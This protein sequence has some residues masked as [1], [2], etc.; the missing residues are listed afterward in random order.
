MSDRPP[1]NRILVANRGEIAVRIMQTC[2]DMGIGT[3][4]V[5]SE[6]DANAL[7]VQRA[8]YAFC[9]GPPAALQSYL[10]ADKIIEAALEAG[11]EAIHPG[12]GFLAENAGFAR[13]VLEAGLVW[14]GPPP[15]V[16]AL[17]G[18]KIASKFL[19][20]QAKV[21]V[22]PGYYG[23]DQ[24]PERIQAEAERIGYPLMVKAAAGGGGKGMRAVERADDLLSALEGARREA[25]SA[26]GDER[27]FLERLLTHPRHI[28]IQIFADSHENAM[29]LGER[30][31]S[32][33]RRHQKVLEESPSPILTSDLRT[34]M[35][36]SALRVV[37]AAGYVNAGTVE[38]L[39]SGDEYYFLEVNTRLQVEH[40]VTEAVTGLD[41]VRLQIEVAAGRPLR[42]SQLDIRL[43]GHAIEARVY[44]EDPRNGFLPATGTIAVFQPPLGPGVRNDVGIFEGAH[45]SPYYDPILAKLVVR[46]E[47]R[48][49]AVARLRRALEHY[50][51]LGV[52]T[53]V[54]FLRWVA[55]HEAFESG[56]MDT[57]FVA[58]YW[59]PGDRDLPAEILVA[60][61]AFDVGASPPQE[62]GRSNPWHQTGGWRMGGSRRVFRYRFGDTV[63]TVS[64]ARAD[65]GRW[66]ITADGFDHEVRIDQGRPGVIVLRQGSAVETFGCARVEGG[67]EVAWRGETY[68]LARPVT[69]EAAHTQT[70]SLRADLRAPMPGTVIKVAVEPGQQVGAHQPLVVMEAMKM[71]HV[72][73]AP[74]PGVVQE[75]MYSEGDLVPA[76]AA[77]VR[78][79]ES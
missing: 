19:A 3:V 26:F 31:C 42:M 36:D 11:A 4:A 58:R 13:A 77:V 23:D 30:E 55:A 10:R 50:L 66:C 57:D 43:R 56:R 71:E 24:S 22:I 78:L 18:D 72:I 74:H 40:P 69:V 75:V 17:L 59:H 33:Q 52:T 68:R 8:D 76:G 1:F 12:Y 47:N 70:Q 51:V 60:A 35:G 54:G 7:H 34:S 63:W 39:F 79:A 46:G 44:A 6:S 53:N 5:F 2:R 14:I 73:E 27:V 20:E 29:Y 48:T 21:P 61:A 16:I 28:E 15:E 37:R 9:I 38:F 64:A 45:I 41:L 49:D 25:K 65:G 67:L 32:I 62:R